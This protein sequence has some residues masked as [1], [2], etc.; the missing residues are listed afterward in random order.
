MHS[1]RGREGRTG[2]RERAKIGEGEKRAECKR[3]GF[4]YGWEGRGK[5]EG[6]G[7]A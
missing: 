7:S 2:R 1:V 5:R 6:G 3:E 4:S